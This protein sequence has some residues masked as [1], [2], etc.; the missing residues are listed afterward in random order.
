MSFI[1]RTPEL[2][3]EIDGLIDNGEFEQAGYLMA[4]GL[5]KHTG[6]TLE[7]MLVT[8]AVIDAIS[9]DGGLPPSY[10]LYNKGLV[11]WVKEQQNA[12]KHQGE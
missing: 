1:K 7:K 6:D 2:Q 8:A 9:T 3:A 11:R 5:Q 4:A 10:K 12:V